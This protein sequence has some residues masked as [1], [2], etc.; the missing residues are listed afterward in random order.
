M[1]RPTI[2]YTLGD[3]ARALGVS[4]QALAN[5][6]AR[7]APRAPVALPD[8]HY[9]TRSGRPLYTREQIETILADRAAADRAALELDRPADCV[10]H[11]TLS[12]VPTPEGE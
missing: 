8:P 9:A 10:Y 11:S 5:R 2:L 6:R 12:S 1:S 4:P 7:G 3:M